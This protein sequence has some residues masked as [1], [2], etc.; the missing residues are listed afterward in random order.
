MLKK[1]TI[2]SPVRSGKI[3][4]SV[5]RKVVKKAPPEKVKDRIK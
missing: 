4:R 5:I 3:K 1:R 2:K